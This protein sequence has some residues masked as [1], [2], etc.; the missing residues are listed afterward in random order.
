LSPGEK[1]KEEAVKELQKSGG[2]QFDPALVALF[3]DMLPKAFK[4]AINPL[5]Y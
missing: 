5:P 3:L 2:S 4:A 1:A